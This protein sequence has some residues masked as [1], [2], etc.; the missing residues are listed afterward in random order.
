M[1]NSY[2]N[3]KINKGRLTQD[4]HKRVIVF[5]DKTYIKKTRKLEH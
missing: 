2:E 5:I 4:G 1:S 3:S